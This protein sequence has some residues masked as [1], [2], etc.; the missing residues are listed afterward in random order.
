MTGAPPYHVPEGALGIDRAAKILQPAAGSFA[1][2][3]SR[4][5]DALRRGQIQIYASRPS[6]RHPLARFSCAWPSNDWFAPDTEPVFWG[7]TRETDDSV[8]A[9]DDYL[10]NGGMLVDRAQIE[11][12]DG[13]RTYQRVTPDLVAEVSLRRTNWTLPEVLAWVATRD[14]EQVAQIACDGA[15]RPEREVEPSPGVKVFEEHRRCASIGWLIRSVSLWHCKC[16]AKT[17]VARE[18][19]ESC[20]CT[21][22]AFNDVFDHVQRE[23]LSAFDQTT[24]KPLEA[25]LL[26]GF[27]LDPSAFKLQAPQQSGPVSFRRVDV[28]RLWPKR[29]NNGGRKPTYDWPSFI[30]HTKELLMDEGGFHEGWMQANC[31]RDMM[32]WCSRNWTRIPSESVVRDKVKAAVR[33]F[34]QEKAGNRLSA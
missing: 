6:P 8:A 29:R 28:E 27:A 11:R 4:I 26:P 34:K 12:L 14:H 25:A 3:R 10:S 23:K 18:A 30:A 15:W 21:V 1:Q 33:E 2:G 16:G 7:R 5:F 9:W 17:D 22:A 32:D 13:P 20:S 31:E 24:S 19:W